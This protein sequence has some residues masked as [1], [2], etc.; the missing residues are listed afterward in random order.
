MASKP[1]VNDPPSLKSPELP[2]QLSE[3]LILTT[4]P[5][6]YTEAENPNT[7]DVLDLVNPVRI[8]ASKFQIWDTHY[9]WRLLG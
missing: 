4:P 8:V 9:M 3:A 7:N 6:L 1:V 2:I 5:S